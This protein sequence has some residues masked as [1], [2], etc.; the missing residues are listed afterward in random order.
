MSQTIFRLKTAVKSVGV[1]E[2]VVIMPDIAEP[3]KWSDVPL[4]GSVDERYHGFNYNYSDGDLKL[5]F[6]CESSHELLSSQYYTYGTDAVVEFIVVDIARDGTETIDYDGKIDF[7]TIDIQPG[8]VSVSI[9]TNDDHSKVNARWE[10]PI[11]LDSVLTLD[12]VQID[13]TPVTEIPMYG[14]TLHEVGQF[15]RQGLDSESK[16]FSAGEGFE[17]GGSFYLLPKMTY[18]APAVVATVASNTT[19]ELS[20]LSGIS[21]LY[22]DVSPLGVVEPPALLTVDA[23]TA[24]SYHVEIDW[25]FRVNVAITKS[26]LLGKAQFAILRFEPVVILTQ[27]G[28]ANQTIALCP[29]KSGDGYVNSVEHSF[30]GSYHAD[31]ELPVGAQLF[32][33]CKIVA[34]TVNRIKQIEFYVEVAN[35]RI[36]IDRKTRAAATITKAYLLPDAL[37]HV[38]GA[39]TSSLVNSPKT[40]AVHGS[41]I[42]KAS[43]D[44]MMDGYATE[45]AITSGYQLRGIDKAPTFTAKMLMDTL[46]SQHAAGILYEKDLTTG[47][48]SMRIEAGEWFYRG[49]EI[50]V[51]DEIFE[52]S[53]EPDLDLLYNQ[54]D[55]GYEKYPDSGTGV[56]EEFNTVH[57]YQTPLISRDSKL[58]I[59]CPLIAAGTAIEEARRLGIKKTVDGKEVSTTTDAGTYDDEG[60][61][62]HVVAFGHA[63]SIRFIVENPTPV[64]PYTA[65]YIQFSNAVINPGAAGVVLNYGDLLTFSGTGTTND[66]KTYKVVGI[67]L[68]ITDFAAT[69]TYEVDSVTSMV[70]G[71]PFS[72]SWQVGT[73]A[74]KLRTSERLTITGVADP[75]TVINAELTPARMLFRHAPFINSGLA[76]KQN[77][78][79]LKCTAYKQNGK[80]TTQVKMGLS[81]LPGDPD[82]Q[83]I[84]ETGS[85]A[86][87]AFQRFDRVFQPEL[88]KVK[89]RITKETR[90]KI[91][92]A[93]KNQ[94][95]E[96]TRCGFLTIINPDGNPVNGFLKSITYNNSSEVVDLV[97][98]KK[99]PTDPNAPNCQAYYDWV[100][101]QFSNN[102]L[103]D[104]NIYRFCRLLDFQPA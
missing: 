24:G 62:L 29:P 23:N 100:Y 99:R 49:A 18:P 32:P 78:D 20:T 37:R 65:H 86:L 40:G 53:E 41:L 59:L 101:N 33:F 43:V 3:V 46:W 87:G 57:T 44:Q 54:I 1:T 88:I 25:L 82:K 58:D 15:A 103:A 12:N 51:I 48:H 71:G 30:E 66:G 38:F 27:P 76:Y 102:P 35:L 96:E 47:E 8:R 85:I 89:G 77:I 17:L 55:V 21:Y 34:F 92:A 90:R 45:Y 80:V 10:S 68:D 70:A 67:K 7:E 72:C 14:Q 16:V 9:V 74:V 5:D 91:F 4:V 26:G 97:V 2:P 73:Q 31:L 19:P 22:G 69:P 50:A 56:A 39:I 95:P 6:T 83:L 81:P 84:R 61:L 52:Y 93:L 11:A 94:G 63:D 60:F 42:D 64:K 36:L 79:E 98:R 13:P 104:P 28:K 75:E